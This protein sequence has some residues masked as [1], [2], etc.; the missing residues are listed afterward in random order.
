MGDALHG[1]NRSNYYSLARAFHD[2]AGTGFVLIRDEQWATTIKPATIDEW[3][4]WMAYFRM[5]KI[6]TSIFQAQGRGTVPAR[7]PHLFD[8]D[9]RK[10]FDDMSAVIYRKELAKRTVD[11]ASALQVAARKATVA[12]TW[13]SAKAA[14]LAEAEEQQRLLRAR[15]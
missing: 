8:A 14:M 9:W 11:V 2:E 7:W 5:R 12:K 3:G 15:K 1:V 6:P 13:P 10:E 4:A